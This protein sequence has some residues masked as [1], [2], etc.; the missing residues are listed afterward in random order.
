MTAITRILV[1]VDFSAHS[2]RA[3]EYAVTMARHFGAVVELFHVV[4]D[5]F[6]AGGW[7]SEMYMADID[8]I[9]KGALEEAGKAIERCRSAVQAGNV[10]IVTSV[11]LGHVANTII[12]HAKA[13][14]ADLIV[15]GTHGRTGLA[16]FII[17][18]VAERVVRMAPC[19]VLTV[20]LEK[21]RDVHA[22][23]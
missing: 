20:G 2:D 23:A 6:E 7:G 13:T 5:P 4:E 1:P 14:H 17:G 8:G 18:S 15:M 16:H 9:R 3:I 19:P 22:A 10:P 12:E 21:A 11:R